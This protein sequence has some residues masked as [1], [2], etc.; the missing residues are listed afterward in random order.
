MYK[1]IY[2]A[3]S[4]AILKQTQLE[5]ISQNMANANTTGY[6]K[7][8]IS[9]QEY[10]FQPEA[11][12]APDGRAMSDLSSIT[13]DLSNGTIIRTG[14]ALDIAIEGDGLL[15]LE[16][17]RYTRQGNLKKNNDGFLTTQ[18]GVKVLGTGGPIQIPSDS[19]EIS[20]D[21]D[22]KVSVMQPGSTLPSEIDTMRV[23][24]FG[25]DVN[26]TKAGDGQ[27]IASGPGTPST[28]GVQQGYLEMSN[29]DTIKEMVHMIDTMRE[30]ESYQ[31]VIQMFDSAAAKVNNDL[32]RL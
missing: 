13:T 11:G 22:G 30:F 31:K 5:V 3:T 28:A 26:I 20:I 24:E 19:T 23:V 16:G 9:F 17:D 4:G 27:L 29:V 15:A 7:D 21:S 25:K 14:N 6:K 32:G 12:R 8:G 2:I 18:S 1:G 10:L